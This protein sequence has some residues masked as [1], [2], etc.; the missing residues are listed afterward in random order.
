[1]LNAASLANQGPLSDNSIRHVFSEVISACRAVQQ[2]VRVAFLGPEHTYSH[3]AVL[4]RFGSSAELSP[5]DTINEVFDEVS[6]GRSQVGVVPVENSTEGHVSATLDALIRTDLRVCG[7]VYLGVNVMVMSRQKE[8][9]HITTLYSHPQ[10]LGP[11]PPV[12]GP[13]S[14]QCEDH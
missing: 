8:L 12:V 4:R 10:P 6:K 3:Q 9:S 11:V 7:E 13:E 5:M 1:V 14:A 2:N